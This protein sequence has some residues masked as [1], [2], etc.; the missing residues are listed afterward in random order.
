MKKSRL[1]QLLT[2]ALLVSF[3]MTFTAC[4][5]DDD[6]VPAEA[7]ITEFAITNAGADGD[8]YVEGVIEDMSILVVVPFE[9]D[10]TALIPEITLSEGATVVPQSGAEVDFSEPRNFVVTNEDLS[11]TYEVTVELAEPTD[12][13]ITDITLISAGDGQEYPTSIDQ[14]QRIIE[15]TFNELQ[16]SVVLI[17][18]IE[19]APQGSTYT[20]STGSDTLNLTEEELYITVAYAGEETTY[21]FDIHITEAG[22]NPDNV[23]NLM[24]LSGASGNVPS[25]ISSDNYNRGAGFDGRYAYVVSRQDGNFVYVWDVENPGE[26]QQQLYLD[27]DVVS[28]GT[29]L[30]S[31]IA[32]NE[33]GIYVSNM[34]MDPGQVFK[35]YRWTDHEDTEPEVVLE[36]TIPDF[37][38]GDDIRLGDALSVIG[39]PPHD[40]Y[41]FASNFAFPNDASEFYKFNFN[42]G[43][44]TVEPEVLPIQPLE[45][46]V[47]GQYGRVN[48][49]PGETD[50]L[51][52]SGAQMGPAIMD[53]NG[54]IKAEIAEPMVQTRSF[55][56]NI[57]EYNDGLYLSYTV[58]REWEAN[59]VWYD[60]I[61]ISEGADIIEAFESV[62]SATIAD[63]R[64]YRN[65]FGAP[66]G[67]FVGGAHSV[68]I[69]ED[70]K[71]RVMAF[72]LNNGFVV[73]EFSN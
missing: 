5:D 23:E 4:S 8:L 51:V 42:N 24:D 33:S 47:M 15:V 9:T 52:V 30:V 50:L 46:V 63:K 25:V 16:S 60:V 27:E 20:T 28:G 29:W 72:G 62:T 12:A 65:E 59:G 68:K 56:P 64:V 70:G 43:D 6:P 61:N 36:Y 18:N 44:K 11:N 3:A 66:A 38:E 22:F 13:A 54:N 31:D 57:W 45:G 7:K 71:P 69:S 37:E 21:N 39:N 49:I 58:N 2:F 1:F 17:E 67:T 53:F 48:P 34:V 35:V 55:T 19:L 32:V 40:G 41:I 73:D 10:I 14:G 26:E